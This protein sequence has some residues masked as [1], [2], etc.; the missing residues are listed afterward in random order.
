ME[1]ERYPSPLAD[2]FRA[3]WHEVSSLVGGGL[4]KPIRA[5]GYD[6]A[7]AQLEQDAERD[8]QAVEAMREQYKYDPNATMIW[9]A[10]CYGRRFVGGA[11]GLNKMC[12]W[13]RF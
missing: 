11:K 6:H 4:A 2:G 7:A 10:G 5:F 8:R 12:R 3:D 1:P 9:E 13:M